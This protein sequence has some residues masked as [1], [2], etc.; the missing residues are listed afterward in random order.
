M[1]VGDKIRECPACGNA[2][3][4][5]QEN[6]WY[7]MCLN[8][9]C[10]L[11]TPEGTQSEVLRIW[12]SRWM[13]NPAA[14]EAG[15]NALRYAWMIENTVGPKATHGM[16]D[17]E[18]HDAWQIAWSAITGAEHDKRTMNNAIDN[19]IKVYAAAGIYP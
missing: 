11:Q 1:S 13:E 12:N 2:A 6:G 15:K 17:P 19:A 18:L 16:S 3:R 10:G 9:F 4:L 8:P 14:F 5:F 7:V